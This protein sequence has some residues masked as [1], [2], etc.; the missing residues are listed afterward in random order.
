MGG[1]AAKPDVVAGGAL[2]DLFADRKGNEFHVKLCH[3]SLRSHDVDCI[4]RFSDTP[5]RSSTCTNASKGRR[6]AVVRSVTIRSRWDEIRQ[7]FT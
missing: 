2:G 6:A 1:E 5:R 3:L 4:N 7:R